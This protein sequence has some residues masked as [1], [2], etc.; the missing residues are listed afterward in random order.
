MRVH[1]DIYA[2]LVAE[3][4]VKSFFYGNVS[5]LLQLI[6]V[7]NCRTKS[8]LCLPLTVVDKS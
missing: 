6:I 2:S 7:S 5:V 1:L 3:G 8:S 4:R